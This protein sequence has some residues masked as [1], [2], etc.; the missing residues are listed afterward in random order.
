MSSQSDRYADWERQQA[1]NRELLTLAA[2][3][4]G[5]PLEWRDVL[6][7]DLRYRSMQ[8]YLRM[9][10][11]HGHDKRMTDLKAWNPRRDDG[12]S[13]RLQVA[14]GIGLIFYPEGVRA[15]VDSMGRAFGVSFSDEPDRNAATCFAVLRAAAAMAG[16]EDGG[17]T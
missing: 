13:R 4:A 6:S 14:L 2:K 17:A 3:A 15:V 10:S 16:S 12:D 11:P 7:A 5:L 9:P 8:P 1:E